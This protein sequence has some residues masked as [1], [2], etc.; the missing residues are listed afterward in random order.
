MNPS[1]GAA[2]LPAAATTAVLVGTDL[3]AGAVPVCGLERLT[4]NRGVCALVEGHAVALFLLAD[5]TVRALANLDP[6]SGAS[7][8]SRGLVG[9]VEGEATVASPMYKQ[10]FSLLDGRCLD[11][12]GVSVTVHRAGVVE[13]NVWVAL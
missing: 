2:T 9:D 4:V 3:P 10:R 6:C 12:D 7:V 11:A 1:E 5:G 8:L 13:D